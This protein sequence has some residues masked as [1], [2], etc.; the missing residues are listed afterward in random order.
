MFV[1]LGM[2]HEMRMRSAILP[3]V[4]FLAVQYVLH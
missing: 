4:A 3:S 2:Q 1:A